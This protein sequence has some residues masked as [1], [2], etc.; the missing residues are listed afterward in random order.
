MFSKNVYLFFF[1]LHKSIII[2]STGI[3]RNILQNTTC[4]IWKKLKKWDQRHILPIVVFQLKV[5]KCVNVYVCIERIFF[6]RVCINVCVSVYGSLNVWMKFRLNECKNFYTVKDK[7]WYESGLTD[8]TSESI[9][10]LC[11]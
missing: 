7:I 11:I 3:W 8:D 2:L 5:S 6:E 10:C 1:G 9:Y 4:C